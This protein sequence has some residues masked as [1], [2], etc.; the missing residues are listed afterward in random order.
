MSDQFLLIFGSVA[1]LGLAII[2]LGFKFSEKTKKVV[3]TT[4]AIIFHV[5]VFGILYHKVSI[6][7][8]ISLVALVFSL[9]IL[10][11]P[12]KIANHVNIKIYRLL[13]YIT[14]FSAFAFSLDYFSGFPVWL[15]AVPLIIY[16]SPYLISPLRKHL[17]LVI[18]VSWLVV[19]SYVGL[20]GYVIY[21]KYNPDADMTFVNQILPQLNIPKSKGKI[22]RI[23]DFNY[24]PDQK[25]PLI[26]K[27]SK[28]DTNSK[29]IKKIT[30]DNNPG[31]SIDQKKNFNSIKTGT[32]INAAVTKGPT[33]IK[34]SP[35][36]NKPQQ[37]KTTPNKQTSNLTSIKDSGPFLNSLQKADQEFLK[38]KTN[39]QS[40]MGKY[41]VLIQENKELKKQIN[42]LEN[43]L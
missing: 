3:E 8:F 20:I 7:L 10:I 33:T 38:L 26:E 43:H 42:G 14:L 24:H 37:I 35:I 34:T 32:T 31:F 1:L 6:N 12:L 40:L 25:D 28:K 30:Q 29:P 18:A 15:W 4:G 41:K 16:L 9:F 27:A 11:D 23:E 36:T 17:K 39:Y 21:S 22:Y 19:F 2:I 13:G 5:G